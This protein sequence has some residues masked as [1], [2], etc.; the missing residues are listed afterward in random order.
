MKKAIW[1]YK[2]VNKNH[3][4]NKHT[5]ES[6]TTEITTYYGNYERNDINEINIKIIDSPGLGDTKGVYQDNEIIKLSK[7]FSSNQT[8]IIVLNK[9]LIFIFWI[10]K[11]KMVMDKD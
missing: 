2:L 4:K 6:Q 9:E 7:D 3:L 10:V 1:R 5:K 11:L 8:K